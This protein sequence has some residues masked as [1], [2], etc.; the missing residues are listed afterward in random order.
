MFL[1][2]VECILPRMGL[3]FRGRKKGGDKKNAILS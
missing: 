2:Y 1:R 3:F